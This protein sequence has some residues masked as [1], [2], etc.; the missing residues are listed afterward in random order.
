[1]IYVVS[2]NYNQARDWMRSHDLQE[3]VEA[4]YVR[5]REVLYGIERGLK[6]V[7][8]GTWYDRQ[9]ITGI[10]RQLIEREAVELSPHN[11]RSA[12]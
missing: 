2:G 7:R 10:N 8:V 5:G 1:M 6:F 12:L 3:R 9:D 11:F 4:N